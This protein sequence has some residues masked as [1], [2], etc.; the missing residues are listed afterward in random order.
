MTS[1]VLELSIYYFEFLCQVIFKRS[2]DFLVKL[3]SHIQSEQIIT[4]IM[5]SQHDFDHFPNLF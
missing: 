4:K 2:N 5:N 1:L 3:L